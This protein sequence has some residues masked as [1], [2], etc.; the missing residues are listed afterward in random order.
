MYAA[1]LNFQFEVFLAPSK[2]SAPV[3]LII[4]FSPSKS[5]RRSSASE[6]TDTES[7]LP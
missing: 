4:V 1:C 3:Q 5:D 2:I 6:A 7:S